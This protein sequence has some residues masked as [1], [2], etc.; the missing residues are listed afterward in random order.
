LHY[1]GID[2]ALV[3]LTVPDLARLQLEGE[4]RLPRQ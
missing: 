3:H 4:G 1:P 2:A